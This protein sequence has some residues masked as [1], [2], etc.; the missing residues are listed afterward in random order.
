[1]KLEQR[2]ITLP[3]PLKDIEPGTVVEYLGIWYLVTDRKDEIG[4]VVQVVRLDNGESRTLDDQTLAMP[5]DGYFQ[6]V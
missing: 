1:M 2:K 6:E 4:E 5:V 3:K